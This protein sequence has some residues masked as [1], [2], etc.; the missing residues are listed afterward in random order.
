MKKL[1]F[2]ALSLES[3]LGCG[4]TEFP[5]YSGRYELQEVSY[6][7]PSFVGEKQLPATLNVVD[8][9]KYV[10][11]EWNHR[12]LFDFIPDSPEQAEGIFSLDLNEVTRIDEGA[13]PNDGY[14]GAEIYQESKVHGPGAFCW[15]KVLYFLHLETVPPP[16]LLPYP[17]YE[18][19]TEEDPNTHENY[20]LT[21]NYPEEVEFDETE[22][23]DA[24]DE[25]EGI[26]LYF[27][28]TRYRKEERADY[29]TCILPSD[30]RSEESLTLVYHASVEDL[31]NDKDI[32]KD[33]IAETVGGQPAVSFF[34]QVVPDIK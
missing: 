1:L 8:R 5:Q 33:G 10:G 14:D 7:N 19:S 13:W 12:L 22:W 4:Y 34:R 2:G 26:T 29:K 27:T 11:V 17:G 21:L 32:R 15:R 30:N 3:L 18:L 28:F 16:E 31:Y 25:N 20:K 6:S 23:Y 24:I 9:M